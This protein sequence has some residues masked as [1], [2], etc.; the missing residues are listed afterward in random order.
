MRKQALAI[1]AI[2][3]LL[4]ACAGEAETT[5]TTQAAQASTTMTGTPS[6]TTA[7]TGTTEAM[8]EMTILETAAAAGG[9]STLITALEAAGLVETLEGDGP[10][11]VFAP[12]DEAF[13]ALPEGTVESLLEDPEALSE[14]LLYHVVPGEVTSEQVVTLDSATTAQGTDLTVTVDGETVMVD[15]A[16]VVSADIAA[17]NGVIH[18]IDAVLLPPDA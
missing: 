8:G 9:F 3:A 6:T 13:A 12:T 11:T 18:V 15:D 17:S 10:F 4:T 7:E 5:T 14:I 1:A 2:L 16:T